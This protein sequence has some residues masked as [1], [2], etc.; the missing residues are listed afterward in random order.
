MRR[1][2]RRGQTQKPLRRWNRELGD[3]LAHGI[4]QSDARKSFIKPHKTSRSNWAGVGWHMG[5][6][7]ASR[8]GPGTRQGGM[9]APY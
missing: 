6:W 4:R 7:G 5:G 2:A 8:Y 3:N 9:F 1:G